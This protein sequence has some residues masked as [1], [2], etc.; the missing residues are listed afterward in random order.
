MEDADQFD[1][2]NEVK[3]LDDKSSERLLRFALILNILALQTVWVDLAFFFHTLS[4]HLPVHK[5]GGL[6][7]IGVFSCFVLSPILSIAAFSRRKKS[8]FTKRLKF[9]CL[10]H[11]VA[12]FSALM[13]IAVLG[14]YV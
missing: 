6:A 2:E 1:V 9:L 10:L 4:F 12:W 14:G 3:Y 11:L 5:P 7:A 8:F 13:S